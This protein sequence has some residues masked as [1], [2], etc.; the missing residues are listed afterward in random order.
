MTI[1][2]VAP[3]QLSK[4]VCPG[5]R[6]LADA[7]KRSR[8]EAPRRLQAVEHVC[9]FSRCFG[10][11]TNPGNGGKVRSSAEVAERQ[12]RCVQDAVRVPS[13]GFKSRPRHR[14]PGISAPGDLLFARPIRRSSW[15]YA[16]SD[17]GL[18]EA[19]ASSW[20][21]GFDMGTREQVRMYSVVEPSASEPVPDHLSSI[22]GALRAQG[23]VTNNDLR[24]A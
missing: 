15:P 24:K 12:T 8:T 9:T 23:H 18:I 5:G 22:L 4:C 13:C 10:K 16:E 17:S 3:C 1:R 21:T 14:S 6:C 7:G 2:C 11:L 20:Y 19:E